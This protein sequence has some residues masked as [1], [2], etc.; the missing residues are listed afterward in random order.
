MV[1]LDDGKLMALVKSFH[2]SQQILE[3]SKTGQGAVLAF[4]FYIASRPAMW[5]SY[6]TGSE[7]SRKL[8]VLAL[9][10]EDKKVGQLVKKNSTP[11]KPMSRKKKHRKTT[12]TVVP[13]VGLFFF[14][15]IFF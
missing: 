10:N 9:Q 11:N 3:V 4:L 12:Q 8:R 5:A 7:S 6:G 13:T 15:L 1:F 14:F 2:W